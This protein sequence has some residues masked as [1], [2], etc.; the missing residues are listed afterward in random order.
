MFKIRRKKLVVVKIITRHSGFGF[1]SALFSTPTLSDGAYAASDG[2]EIMR[3]AAAELKSVT[4][5]M[6][7][8]VAKSRVSGIKTTILLLKTRQTITVLTRDQMVRQRTTF[9]PNVLNYTKNAFT[10]YLGSSN[11][12]DEVVIRRFCYMSHNDLRENASNLKDTSVQF[13]V[14]NLT[15]SPPAA[16]KK[17]VSTATAAACSPQSTIA[18][19]IWYPAPPAAHSHVAVGIF[20]PQGGG[21][22]WPLH[23]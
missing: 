9:V 18:N 8:I 17:R 3:D 10:N 5:P 14:N 7:R 23:Q 21:K 22:S 19:N 20:S 12:N 6:K 15:M 1:Q 2:E 11:R 16:E 13:N 4:L